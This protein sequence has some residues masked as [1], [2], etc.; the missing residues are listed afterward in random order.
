VSANAPLVL[1]ADDADDILALVGAALT[2]AGYDVV[3]AGDGEAA[4]EGIR[5]QRPALAVLDV[6]M[7]KLDGLEVVGRLRKDPEFADFPIVLLSARAQEADVERGYSLGASK[8]VRKPFSPRE[9]I[10]IVDELI[11]A[12]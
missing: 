9:L 11:G 4:L 5:S 3:T 10:A 2:R 6:S 7:P 12:S 8:Y 1:V